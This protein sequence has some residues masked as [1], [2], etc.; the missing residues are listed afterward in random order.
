MPALYWVY[1]KYMKNEKE[2]ICDLGHGPIYL[3]N[4]GTT[5]N[6]LFYRLLAEIL[7]LDL[8]QG[9]QI[10]FGS[11]WKTMAIVSEFERFIIISRMR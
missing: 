7:Y 11:D 3:S 10:I 4:C 5:R 2:Q 1:G 8:P 6:E 9:R